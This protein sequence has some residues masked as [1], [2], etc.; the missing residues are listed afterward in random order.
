MTT[1]SFHVN[2]LNSLSNPT[3]EVQFSQPSLRESSSNA[4][5]TAPG[6]ATGQVQY[7]QPW[8]GASHNQY[9]Q[10]NYIDGG[11]G[12]Q[13]LAM[14]K[15]RNEALKGSH[16]GV[17]DS[18]GPATQ[19]ELAQPPISG[20][21]G[22]G[23]LQSFQGDYGQMQY[24]QPGFANPR[25][26]MSSNSGIVGCQ[27][28]FP[29]VFDNHGSGVDSTINRPDI[30]SQPPI[31]HVPNLTLVAGSVMAPSIPFSRRILSAVVNSRPRQNS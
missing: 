13:L 23:L 18:L 2:T 1:D 8:L 6:L 14:S 4:I 30:V 10:L 5:F 29:F 26:A 16:V 22:M 7:S 21:G 20:L 27:T 25:S 15:K 11:E 12:V 17:G 9:L 24:F 31:I 28:Q 19:G 3:D